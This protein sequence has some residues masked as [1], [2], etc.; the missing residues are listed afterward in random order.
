M[1][2]FLRT[3]VAV[4][5]MAALAGCSTLG[6]NNS[7]TSTQQITKPPMAEA[8]A[9]PKMDPASGLKLARMLVEQQRLEGAVGIYSQLA[10][11][12]ALTP[13]EYLEYADVA[14]LI[15]PPAQTLGVFRAAQKLGEDKSVNW[16]PQ[17]AARLYTGLGRGELASGQV[18]DAAAHLA[19]AVKADPKN[20]A[21]LNAQGVALSALGENDQALA[22]LNEAIRL[23]PTNAR[24]R[25]NKALVLCAQ[26]QTKA[27]VKE[28]LEA[29][30]ADDKDP[31]IKL[32][33][34]FLQWYAGDQE[35]AHERLAKF[36]RP[37]QVEAFEKQFDDMLGRIR[38]GEST[39]NEEL[40]HSADKLVDILP[41]DETE[42]AVPYGTP[43]PVL[44]VLPEGNRAHVLQKGEQRLPQDPAAAAKA[45]EAQQIQGNQVSPVTSGA[46]AVPAAGEGK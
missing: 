13:Q 12:D 38:A 35:R 20:V 24:V 22:A 19:E 29:E 6:S 44:N 18:K 27:A 39:V 28:L 17:E 1:K 3:V 7:R 32:N 26:D 9:N 33:L 11:R 45:L 42:A 40:L 21:A 31:T 30:R 46:E 8:I 25:S 43:A 37:S 4:A 36:L 10:R 23:Q 14:S 16:T 2:R 34:A 15:I 5:A 41:Q